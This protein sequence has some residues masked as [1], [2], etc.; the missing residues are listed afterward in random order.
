MDQ[1]LKNRSIYDRLG[2]RVVDQNWVEYEEEGDE[3]EHVW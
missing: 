1:R 3:E 2:K